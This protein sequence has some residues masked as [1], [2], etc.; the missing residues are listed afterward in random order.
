MPTPSTIVQLGERSYPIYAGTGLIADFGATCRLHGLND[1]VAV[2]TDR[3][4]AAYHL[5]PLL[6]TLRRSGF[7]PMTIVLPPGERQKSLRR[8]YAIYTSLLRGG[9]GRTS[10][11][12]AFGGGV[13]GDLAGFVAATYQRGIPVV[14]VPT[15]LLAQVDS[16]I[17]GKTGVN[18]PLGKNMIGAF[19][20]PRFVWA[21]AAYLR[22]LPRRELIS[23]IGE[24]IKYA[25]IRDEVFFRVLEAGLEDLLNLGEDAVARAQAVCAGIKASLVSSDECERGERIVLNFGHTIGHALEAA[26]RYRLLRHGE[27]VLLG[28]RAESAIARALGLLSGNDG[29]RIDA[30]IRRVPIHAHIGSLR[31][32]EILAA[33]GHDKKRAGARNR[34]VLPVGVGATRV[35]PDVD[36]RL[37]RTALR[38]LLSPASQ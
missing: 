5:S 32:A 36:L 29:E 23:G 12:I 30:L 2:I 20:Q 9:I 22:T 38:E 28:M 21:D 10:G 37:V 17:G 35:V 15:T 7:R 16:S 18:H 6:Q 27:A 8:A 25:V 3:T 34:F 19:H 13:V 11:V 1:P 26:G 4:V 24:V 33:M 14:Q 31:P